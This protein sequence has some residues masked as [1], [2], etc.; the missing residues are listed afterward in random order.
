MTEL[1][2]EILV[3]AARDRARLLYD[4]VDVA[5]RSCGI[6]IAET[7]GYPTR[8][9]QALRK[10]GLTGEGECGA[11]RAGTLLLG[12]IFGDPDPTGPATEELKLAITI[13]DRL[14]P[15]VVDL[16][17]SESIICNALTGQF[18]SFVSPERHA[19]C[20]DLAA[21]VAYCVARVVV[22]MGGEPTLGEPPDA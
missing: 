20:T 2:L 4:G 21:S 9:Y 1:D 12:E 11:I 22:E 16:G 7:F 6:A 15:S 3:N 19:F 10:G 18:T 5:H 14:W 13:Y 17:E 8:S